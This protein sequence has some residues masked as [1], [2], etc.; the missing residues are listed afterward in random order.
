MPTVTPTLLGISLLL[1]LYFLQAYHPK[2][3]SIDLDQ[4]APICNQL[5]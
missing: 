3:P 5:D 1:K 4:F 2:L